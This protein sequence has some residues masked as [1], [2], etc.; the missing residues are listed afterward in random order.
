[1]AV[2]IVGGERKGTAL[3]TLPGTATRP[4]LGRVRRSLFDILGPRVVDARVL[5]LFAGSGAV[6]L[7]ALSRGARW[8]TLVEAGP[9]AL[10]VIRKNINKLRYG[11]CTRVVKGR[12]PA[13]VDSL[14]L[15]PGLARYDV[16]S[17]MPP[18][19][20][21]LL[22]PTLER[23]AR[24][25]DLF[26]PHALLVGQFETGEPVPDPPPEVL[27]P[28]DERIYGQTHLV[29]WEWRGPGGRNAA[30]PEGDQVA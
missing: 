19:G 9:G 23:L 22:P 26:A 24:R 20:E 5:D 17:I 30:P 12:L 18:Y 4:L 7:E 14:P 6:G 13:A 16:V 29:F 11:D 21:G 25:P 2:R 27:E 28:I 8:L 3:A 10:D 1:M 15:P